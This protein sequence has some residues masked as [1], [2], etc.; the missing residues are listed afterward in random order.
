MFHRNKQLNFKDKWVLVTGASS[1]LGRQMCIDLA[2]TYGAKILALARSTDK[3]RSL[4][5]QIKEKSDIEIYSVDLTDTK[6]LHTTF[7]ELVAKHELY[8]V[9]LNAGVTA[10]D[11]DHQ[12]DLTRK[13]Q[14]IAT[15]VAHTTEL[16][17]L[18]IQYFRQSN[19]PG[20]ILFISSMASRIPLPWQALYSATKSFITHY[21]SALAWENRNSGITI[22]VSLPGGIQTE[23]IRK[24]ELDHLSAWLLPVEK[25][26]HLTLEG[27][28][29][30]K[31]VFT[32]TFLD[33][34]QVFLAKVAPQGL[35]NQVLDRVYRKPSK[36]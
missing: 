3:L 15:N 2:E 6:K 12:V 32:L 33:A 7:T 16:A 21:A 23:M 19:Q 8:A 30:G 35:V 24:N 22:S 31:K 26:S 29:K 13:K 34:L 4:Q 10:F 36:K 28:R 18:A 1:G 5:K 20:G 27:F 9:I 17:H 11:L 25:A 14:L